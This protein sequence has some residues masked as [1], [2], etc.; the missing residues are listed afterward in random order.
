MCFLLIR[1]VTV[2]D[3][4]TKR[5]GIAGRAVPAGVLPRTTRAAVERSRRWRGQSEQILDLSRRDEKGV[6]KLEEPATPPGEHAHRPDRGHLAIDLRVKRAKLFGPGRLCRAGFFTHSTTLIHLDAWKSRRRSHPRY[7]PGRGPSPGRRIEHAANLRAIRHFPA[8]M[9]RS[10]TGP[11]EPGRRCNPPSCPRK[12]SRRPVSRPGCIAG[13]PSGRTWPKTRQ[14][15]GPDRQQSPRSL[16]AIPIRNLV[17]PCNKR[18]TECTKRQVHP[19]TRAFR[20][21][22]CS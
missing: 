14:R 17:L 19:G 16:R 15:S 18:H 22:A 5:P 8:R 3:T 10:D 4:A 6:S 11:A 2:I 9:A 21:R 7:T 12:C 13:R 1:G 20:L